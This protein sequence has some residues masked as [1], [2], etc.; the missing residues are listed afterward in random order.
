MD[1]YPL[2]SANARKDRDEAL[3]QVSDNAGGDWLSE[4][5]K[6]VAAMTGEFTG[7][8]I[9]VHCQGLGIHPHHHNAWGALTN[10]LLRRGVITKTGR[11]R[12]MYTKRS[13]A[14]S[15]PTYTRT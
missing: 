15:T 14:R 11:L 3:K 5:Q 2:F 8:D 13:H 1:E 9:R 10:L 12:S 7:E 4:A 6:A